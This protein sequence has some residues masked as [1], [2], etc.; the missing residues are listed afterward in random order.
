MR[1]APA[2]PRARA[3]QLAR[4]L[5]LARS[6]VWLEL[7]RDRVPRFDTGARTLPN[8][9]ATSKGISA[10]VPPRSFLTSVAVNRSTVNS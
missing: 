1:V 7:H 5:D 10:V 9:A 8:T 3:R 6:L 4:N 2:R